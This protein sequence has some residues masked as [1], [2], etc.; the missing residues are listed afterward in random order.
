[1]SL[2]GFLVGSR[3]TATP[4]ALVCAVFLILLLAPGGSLEAQPRTLSLDKTGMLDVGADGLATPGDLINYTFTVG[5]S[6]EPGECSDIENLV[7]TDTLLG[8]IDCG[9]TPVTVPPG[10]LQC[11]ASY[12]ITQ[13]DIDAGSVYNVATATGGAFCEITVEATDDHLEPIEQVAS[14]ELQKTGTLDMGG[15]GIANPGDEITY[16]LTVTNN[17][18]VTLTDATLTDTVLASFTCGG[19]VH[20]IPTL[21]PG[22]SES[23]GGTYAI[24][25]ADIDAGSKENTA[26]VTADEPG[27]QQTPP[28]GSRIASSQ[29]TM[30]VPIPQQPSIQISK[31]GTPDFGADGFA[32]PGDLINYS[33]QVG[34]PGNVTLTA[35]AVSDPLI[36]PVTCPSGNPIPTF[37]PGASEMCTGSYAL[38]AADIAAGSR[39]NTADASGMDPMTQPVSA[40]DADMV[41]LPA[42]VPATA[43]FGLLILA[44]A[45]GV[46]GV[47]ALRRRTLAR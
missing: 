30:L 13:A 17:G 39:S 41:P 12:P 3:A 11:F 1:M 20:P 31:T 38:T 16:E 23:C 22:S 29:M 33:F 42:A 15:D 26:E 6:N 24:T 8:T 46:A 21:A 37:A 25:Q 27:G 35:V 10:Q 34:N 5:N 2:T 40:G 45:L 28:T 44:L 18:N 9:P 32:D 14:I 36:S 7:V 19:G 4:L 47:L 43:A